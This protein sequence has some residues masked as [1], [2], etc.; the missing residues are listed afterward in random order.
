MG[1]RATKNR[2]KFNTFTV[3]EVGLLFTYF[4]VGSGL[5]GCGNAFRTIFFTKSASALRFLL[6]NIN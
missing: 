1:S 5:G 6:F 4:F 2:E 3:L